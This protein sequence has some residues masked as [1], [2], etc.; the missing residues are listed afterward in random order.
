MHSVR[1]FSL[2]F[3]PWVSVGFLLFYYYGVFLLVAHVEAHVAHFR[4]AK[5]MLDRERSED[6]CY[7]P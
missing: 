2:L 4:T 1:S 5:N 6:T 3:F 7:G